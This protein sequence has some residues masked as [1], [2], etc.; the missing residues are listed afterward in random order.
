MTKVE[1][2]EELKE[3]YRKLVSYRDMVTRLEKNGDFIK[4]IY[5]YYCTYE[6]ARYAQQSVNQ[7][8]PAENR[9][10]A[11]Q[12]A[13]AAGF[14]KEFLVQTKILGDRAEQEMECIDEEI[15]ALTGEQ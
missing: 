8:L 12:C 2:L 4:L 14:L 7:A 5:E 13:Q 6:C 9:E 15:V 10:S 3:Q 1:E 11:L